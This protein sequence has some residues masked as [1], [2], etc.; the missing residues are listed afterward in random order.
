[1][2]LRTYILRFLLQTTTLLALL[3]SSSQVFAVV[4]F[5]EQRGPKQVIVDFQMLLIAAGGL[6]FLTI[7]LFA[8][9]AF[10]KRKL[11]KAIEQHQYIIKSLPCG[12]VH[13]GLNGN[14]L[15][16]NDIAASQLG[17]QHDKLMNQSFV[18]N[19]DEALKEDIEASLNKKGRSVLARTRSSNLYLEIQSGET[20]MDGEPAYTVITLTN[21]NALKRQ[22]DKTLAQKDRLTLLVETSKQGQVLI[23]TTRD[24]YVYD[25]VFA[26]LLG[27]EKCNE[28]DKKAKPVSVSEFA[29][30][31]HNHDI[32]AWTKALEQ[33]SEDG[34]A[35]FSARM[36]MS[37]ADEN[38]QYIPVE[39][40]IIATKKN[41]ID[42]DL[43]ERGPDFTQFTLLVRVEYEMES[44]KRKI[45]RYKQQH[46][47]ILNASS[48]AT[49]AINQDGKILWSN[50]RF[51]KLLK[52]LMPDAS[53]ENLLSLNP[54]PE[55]VMQLHK[56][57]PFMS[58]QTY[59]AEFEVTSDDG[60]A[61]FLKLDLAYYSQKDRL[62]EQQSVGIVGIIQ[63]ISDIT[64]TRK[65]LRQE[66]GRV[67]NTNKELKAEQERIVAINKVL[68][69]EQEQ[70]AL[71]SK[72]LKQEQERYA[73]TSRELQ[74]EQE[75]MTRLLELSPVAIAT[76]D[77]DDQII[78]ANS[79]MLERLKYNEKELKK[80]NI[81][82][83]FSEPG[84]A[85]TAAKH[86]NKTG[87]LRDFHVRLKGKDGKIYP[88]ELKVDLINKEKQEYLFWIV[89]RSDEQFQRDKFEGIL[90]GSNLPMAILTD[91]GFSKLNQSA[92][93]LLGAE[94]E[95]DLFGLTPY[96]K[97]L[98]DNDESANELMQIISD[99]RR[100]NEVKSILWTHQIDQKA[101]ACRITFVPIYK[102]QEFDSIICV[103]NDQRELQK[104][105][106]AR[107]VAINARKEVEVKIAENE[108][109]LASKQQEIAT[110][111]LQQSKLEKT[112]QAAQEDLSHT[113]SEFTNLQQSHEQT[114][115]ALLQLQDE[116]SQTQDVLATSQGHNEDLNVQLQA[117][118]AELSA[119]E[120]KRTELVSTL[121][122]S[123]QKHE[124]AQKAIKVKEEALQELTTQQQAQ[125]QQVQALNEQ[126]T[127][128][129]ASLDAKD[130]QLLAL[131]QHIEQVQNE[132]LNATDESSEL[133]QKLSEQLQ[134]RE[135]SEQEKVDLEQSYQHAKAELSDAAEQT[136]QQEIDAK[137]RELTEA[138]QA[139]EEAK[140]QAL[141]DRKARIENEQEVEQLNFVLNDL[142]ARSEQ[143]KD[144]LN[145][146]EEQWQQQHQE[147]EQQKTTLE[148]AL[149]DEQM[150]KQMLQ[151]A[152]DAKL[153]TL[154]QTQAQ[155]VEA[156]IAHED[157]RNALEQT[158][159]QAGDLKNLI[160]AKEKEEERYRQELFDQEQSL[161]YPGSS[162]IDQAMQKQKALNEE[163]SVM[164]ASYDSTE[165]NLQEQQSVHSDLNQKMLEL[166][167][168]LAASQQEL[169]EKEDELGLAQKSLE[170]NEVKLREQ[171]SALSQAQE[172]AIDTNSEE[173]QSRAVARPEIENLPMPNNPKVWFDLLSFLKGSPQDEPLPQALGNLLGEL[174][175]SIAQ[176]EDL[177]QNDD[178]EGI[179]R[180]SKSLLKL[181]EKVH[182]DA[183]MHL[184]QSIA[185][186]CKDGMADNMSIRWPATKQGIQRTIRVVY[187][188]MH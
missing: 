144:A 172:K 22:F 143:H 150:Q 7:T 56:N 175:K 12:V 168:A 49:Y 170:A 51:H 134:A 116:Y 90:Q 162:I 183:L 171:E 87:R 20:I 142:R 73:H 28:E 136:L 152:L 135:K 140:V 109:L 61:I 138:K 80:G 114:N 42:E 101:L 137:D 92:C 151:E 161:E 75:R 68:S 36:Q 174:E 132:L 23:D 121:Q 65:E 128:L 48:N 115:N 69:K 53:F 160:E 43:K 88:G 98:N 34:S 31:M 164:Q 157:A 25:D 39:I 41:V 59:E 107:V 60:R 97:Q 58:T 166:E 182:S 177:L 165:K 66:R 133:N 163:L 100:T 119:L 108:K 91:N 113:Q 79:V 179:K 95:E 111:E 110:K 47:A 55:D 145:G 105:E 125:T 127:E 178:F 15:Y 167:Q 2:K 158:Q 82:K 120:E 169:A 85:G 154:E 153:S 139:L 32:D 64:Q 155:L 156:Q 71:T 10:R 62:S 57:V 185:N 86:L 99:V 123:E 46:E 176:T 18:T 33:A 129:K 187:S 93:E 9:S 29:K 63:D 74:Q 148:Q 173:G 124:E 37:E 6:L 77:S 8:L 26:N 83:L 76:I 102:D 78:S 52:R 122:E 30:R 50:T 117:S 44:Q 4:Q 13:V 149:K 186:D 141:S 84:E 19:F 35:K 27:L 146:N 104:I 147:L 5:L 112:L 67:A 89:D 24:T 181:A 131:N 94:D 159:A 96:S 118:N 106:E 16:F 180:I 126:I 81:Y 103:W 11:R 14:I 3:A 130:E 40:H 45:D 188:H 70:L 54:F 21:H 184:M 17:R 72:D 1:M 38:I